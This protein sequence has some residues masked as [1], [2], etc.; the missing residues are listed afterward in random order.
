[1][2]IYTR[3]LEK[4]KTFYDY[5]DKESRIIRNFIDDLQSLNKDFFYSPKRSE[6]SITE[7][8]AGETLVALLNLADN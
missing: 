1:M 7:Y 5:N 8:A 4:L 2:A 3:K 6:E